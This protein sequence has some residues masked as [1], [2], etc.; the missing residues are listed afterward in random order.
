ML[1]APFAGAVGLTRPFSED[2]VGS[3]AANDGCADRR[4]PQGR[5]RQDGK[6]DEY[7]DDPSE[8]ELHRKQT[9]AI[10]RAAVNI[11][12]VWCMFTSYNSS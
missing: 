10:C 5:L 2:E 12:L 4:R 7:P 9:L 6:R 8:Q 1:P 3:T 11:K